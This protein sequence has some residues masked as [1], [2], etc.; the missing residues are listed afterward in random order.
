MAYIDRDQFWMREHFDDQ[1]RR[2]RDLVSDR[3]RTWR[4]MAIVSERESEFDAAYLDTKTQ[5][6]LLARYTQ[7]VTGASI[8]VARDI[9]DQGDISWVVLIAQQM[10]GDLSGTMPKLQLV[11][12]DAG[13]F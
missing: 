13:D 5:N 9:L 10:Q 11:S 1:T 8:A 7:T 3:H 6:V 4:L 2:I 12:R